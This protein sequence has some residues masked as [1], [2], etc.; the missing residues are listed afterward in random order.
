MQAAI[1]AK[2]VLLRQAYKQSTEAEAKCNQLQQ[3]LHEALEH[4]R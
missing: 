1:Q 3:Q 4:A 2:Q